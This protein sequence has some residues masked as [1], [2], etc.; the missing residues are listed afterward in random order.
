[1]SIDVYRH[2]NEIEFTS[3]LFGH[4]P[5]GPSFNPVAHLEPNSKR[6]IKYGSKTAGSGS[7]NE[8]F[9]GTPPQPAHVLLLLAPVPRVQ[10]A[11]YAGKPSG[12]EPFCARRATTTGRRRRSP[13]IL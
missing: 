8:S 7:A 6:R 3:E 12:E 5:R 9:N 2:S 10:S 11:N 13:R 1:M 4:R